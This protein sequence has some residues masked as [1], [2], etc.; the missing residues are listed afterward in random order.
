MQGTLAM[1]RLLLVR[2][3]PIACALLALA[4][5]LGI[6][7]LPNSATA[8]FNAGPDEVD[9]AAVRKSIERGCKYLLSQQEPDGTWGAH[10]GYPGGMT[11]LCV[12][13]LVNSG[14]PTDNP[15]LAKAIAKLT[16]YEK[17]GGEAKIYSSALIV[18]TLCA[19]DPKKYANIISNHA[20]W[21]AN[22]QLKD[23]SYRGG[24]SYD[25]P[26]GRADNSN[27]QF[28]ILGLHEA[29][30]AGVI[31]VDQALWQRVEQYWK[32]GQNKN[33]GAN[34][35]SWAYVNSG[36]V[37]NGGQRIGNQPGT[38]SMTCAGLCSLMIA[39]SKLVNGDAKLNGENPLCCQDD[40][41]DTA[42]EDG[43]KWLGAQSTV[44]HNPPQGMGWHYYYLYG[45]ERTGR[46]SGQRF[47]YRNGNPFD[48]YRQ[49]CT[50]LLNDQDKLGSGKWDGSRMEGDA[51]VATALALLFLSKGR[52]PVVMAKA[53]WG[54]G[55]DWNQY[56]ND[57]AN[58]TSYVET[59]WKKDFPIGLS[60]QV[61]NLERATVEDLLQSPVL[62]I[63][64]SK[65]MIWTPQ[66]VQ[67]LREYID[68]GG[69]IFAEACCDGP[70]AEGFD[71]AFREAVKKMFADK[72]E[73]QLKMLDAMHPVYRAEI[74]VD[75]VIDIWGVDYG[76]RTCIAYV[77]PP[78][79]ELKGNLGC[80]WELDIARQHNMQM[81]GERMMRSAFAIGLNVLAYA[82]NRE[83][84]SKDE[85]LN[86]KASNIKPDTGNRAL[87]YLAKLR[88]DGGCDT[89]P[90]A[91]PGILRAAEQ[92]L[93]FRVAVEPRLIDIGGKAIFDYHMVFM[94]GR[95]SFTLKK[96]E[97]KQLREFVERGGTILAD[98]I[99][100]SP[101]FTESF[102][103]EMKRVFPQAAL[104]PI[105]A[106]DP[107]LTNKFGGFDLA[108][109]TR[110]Q[111]RG[112]ADGPLDA[113]KRVGPAELEGIKIGDRWAV[114]FSKYDLSCALE[115]HDSLECE[116]YIRDDA[117]RISLNVLL[118]SLGK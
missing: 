77:P 101:A 96:D 67:L 4:A 44:D 56:R 106:N 76:C 116:G 95:N 75:P 103:T 63:S 33:Q 12:L 60:W 108:R 52:R 42:I 66:Y 72:P 87:V 81:R 94:H 61:V 27:S 88:H 102:R 8:Q 65:G 92:Q 50:Q 100:S 16:A 97:P 105:P 9:A 51:R 21:I 84:K 99:C 86:L 26:G 13:A 55:D 31:P 6:A 43:L 117:E 107:L 19:V 79:G 53:Q 91:L 111:P 74:P 104:E 18:M 45:L 90:G 64:G 98:S 25:R 37:D 70:G 59:M 39:R 49:G 113:A 85:N 2:R 36:T 78:R 83:L 28:A 40:K 38:G 29:E 24:W 109:V 93:N 10:T 114:I 57:A 89:A 82:T 58:L 30:R 5:L 32:T 22:Q 115:R 62:Y 112:A 73:H 41:K 3:F 15:Q 46:L 48:W 47:L 23:G 20:T 17:P 1:L 34:S 80:W 11:A 118:Y 35:G 14:I 54:T 71:R 110:R 69:F 7:L 68:R